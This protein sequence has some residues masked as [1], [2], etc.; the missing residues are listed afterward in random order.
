LAMK[1]AGAFALPPDVAKCTLDLPREL[2]VTWNTADT[3]PPVP[4]V[5]VTSPM[6][7]VG[8]TAAFAA[9]GNAGTNPTTTRAMDAPRLEMRAR[10]ERVTVE[11]PLT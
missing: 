5:T 8:R 11:I 2:F 3:V 4:S 1:S 10:W 7:I 9:L 6:E